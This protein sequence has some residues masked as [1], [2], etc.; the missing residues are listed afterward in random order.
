MGTL[1]ELANAMVK[2]FQQLDLA[3]RHHVRKEVYEKIT[4]LPYRE[5]NP[6]EKKSQP[7]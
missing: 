6:G 2:S 5:E 3:A 1:S 7:S 4:G